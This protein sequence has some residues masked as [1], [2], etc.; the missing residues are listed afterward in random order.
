MCYRLHTS[1]SITKSRSPSRSRTI[2]RLP[3]AWLS[4]PMA[5][6]N[7]ESPA[8]ALH[9]QTAGQPHASAA[10]ADTFQNEANFHAATSQ[11]TFE[12]GISMTETVIK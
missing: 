11:T 6:A 3:S 8:P 9:V 10:L 1:I 7:P 5:F 2:S 4:L 12:S